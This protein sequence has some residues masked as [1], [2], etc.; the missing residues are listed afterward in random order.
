[1][2]HNLIE[3]VLLGA[4]AHVRVEGTWDDDLMK[5]VKPATA[6]QR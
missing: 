4:V 6:V 3:A 2:N 1:V 5:Q